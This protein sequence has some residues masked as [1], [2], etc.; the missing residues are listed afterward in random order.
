MY[1]NLFLHYHCPE[2]AIATVSRLHLIL[3]FHEAGQVDIVDNGNNIIDP[4]AVLVRILCL[5]Q[6]NVYLTLHLLPQES[7]IS[8][9]K[10]L[11]LEHLDIDLRC[12][13]PSEYWDSD[14]PVTPA[15]TVSAMN[16]HLRLMD[17][18]A[19]ARRLALFII[20]LKD[21]RIKF[22]QQQQAGKSWRVARPLHGEPDVVLEEYL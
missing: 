8:S 10:R 15:S 7:C 2:S 4:P 11:P 12:E 6:A 14:G 19:L 1:S 9:L 22:S 17:V 5:S 20:P 3:D 13:P 21:I 18:T 16:A